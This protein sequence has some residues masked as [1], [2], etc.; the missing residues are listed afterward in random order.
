MYY[1]FRETN[2]KRIYMNV[3]KC[4]KGDN[5]NECPERCLKKQN[6]EEEIMCK[7]RMNP[8]SSKQT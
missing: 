8:D 5:E 2:E 6:E 3:L 4:T 7:T 1:G